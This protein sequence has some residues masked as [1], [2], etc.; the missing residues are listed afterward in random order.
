MKI[1]GIPVGTTLRPVFSKGTGTDS[2]VQ[3]STTGNDNKAYAPSGTALG[4]K[5]VAGVK[6]F[7]MIAVDK[8]N[9]LITVDDA[10]LAEKAS[11]VYTVGDTLQFEA[12]KHYYDKLGI[13][14]LSTNES[15]QSVIGVEQLTDETLDFTL[16]DDSAKNFCWV[17]G[18]NYGEPFHEGGQHSEGV[19]TVAGGRASHAEGKNTKAMG[20]YSHAEGKGTTAHCMA[21]AEGI[22]TEAFGNYSHAEG[23]SSKAHGY[24]SHAEGFLTLAEG[25]YS[26]AEG[27]QAEA[28]GKYSHAE[29][30]TGGGDKTVAT[31]EGS[32]AEGR[33]TKARGD[34]SHSEGYRTK[35]DKYAHSEGFYAQATG[36]ASHAEGGNTN[37]A[38][39]YSH[40]E[41][42][43]SIASGNYSHAEGSS[44]QA[45]NT[46]AHAEGTGSIASGP[47]SHAEGSGKA[48]A[49]R[50][51]AEGAST[52]AKGSFSH[53]E[54]KYSTA[55]GEGSHAEGD[56]TTATGKYAHAEG[57]STKASS[58]Y[59]HV[60]GQ[61]NI[62]D[63]EGKYAHII[64]NGAA[65]SKPANAHTVD[66]DGNAWYAGKVT[67]GADP[68]NPMD[69]VTKQ[70]MNSYGLGAAESNHIKDCNDATE[71]GWYYVN[72]GAANAPWASGS[73]MLV[74][75]QSVNF[76]SQRISNEMYG[77]VVA[78]RFM[79]NYV[80]GE[81]EWVNPPMVPGVEYRT[82]ERYEGKP[83]Y[84]YHG[85][86][87][88]PLSEG[89]QFSGIV[90]IET[91]ATD[92]YR[93]IK[94]Y[95]HLKITET[96]QYYAPGSE[97][98]FDSGEFH[99]LSVKFNNLY[100]DGSSK[101]FSYTIYYIK[102]E[103]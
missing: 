5:T 18:K 7:R 80:W 53:A 85:Q 19:S 12:D 38:G 84:V 99:C 17:L 68:T 33:G 21:H 60:Q 44:S 16:H 103:D 101:T 49:D 74:E 51:H 73:W 67:A 29:G 28:R 6:G 42:I 37:A 66:W 100:G 57:R 43:R 76:K 78:Q 26:H 58:D 54:G 34:S 55:E 23:Q 39:I 8:A 90:E 102:A 59:Q 62:P 40:A 65:S 14:S 32:H 82:T 10:N 93:I 30:G 20:S 71:T 4:A 47:A 15:G 22:Y 9:M 91:G 87:A 63:T 2:V 95:G 61:F 25:E 45:S 41:G 75:S 46:N 52:N 24:T 79:K 50:S 13:S 92:C 72:N 35:A 56:S 81:W 98:N 89:V 86:Y 70:Y 48:T 1:K 27:Y 64:G 94:A 69:L 3:A 31:G 77:G 88:V 36:E 83:V 11:E 97:C 96:G